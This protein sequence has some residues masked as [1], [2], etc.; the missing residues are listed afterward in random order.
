MSILIN[1]YTNQLMLKPG[2]YLKL[3][4]NIFESMK[5]AIIN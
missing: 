4:E 1:F 2:I 5:K 3:A